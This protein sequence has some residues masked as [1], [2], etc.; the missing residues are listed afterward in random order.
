[1]TILENILAEIDLQY[2][3]NNYVKGVVTQHLSALSVEDVAAE[4]QKVFG[5]ALD[6]Q[7]K[8]A[9]RAVLALIRREP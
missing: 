8:I 5:L 9:A 1:M 7:C 2:R 3:D 6:E 4:I